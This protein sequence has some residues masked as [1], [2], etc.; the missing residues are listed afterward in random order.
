MDYRET[1]TGACERIEEAAGQFCV[2][3]IA[4]ECRRY[5]N[6]HINDT[7]LLRTEDGE[8][9][10]A[11][12]L[13]R[14]NTH[15]FQ[16]PEDLMRNVSGV[17][18]YLRDQIIKGGGDPQRETLT[19]VKTK[20]GKDC[21]VDSLGSWW[22]MYLFIPDALGYDTAEKEG[23]FYQSAKAFGH[24]QRLLAG[25]PVQKLT[26]TIPDFHNT[27]KRFEAFCRAVEKDVCGRAQGVGSEIAFVMDRKTEMSIVTDKLESGEIPRRVTHN[28]TKLNNVL[29]DIRS[30]QAV[31]VID[32][33]TVMPGTAVYDF[34]DSIRFGANTAEEDER[35]LSR[36]SL[37][38]P[39]YETYTKGFLEGCAGSLTDEEIR[40]L[41]WG[42]K[43]MTL[44]CGMRFLTDYLEGDRYFRIHRPEHNLDRARTQF[45]LAA[46]MER[47]WDE[48][49]RLA[50]E[51]IFG[52]AGAESESVR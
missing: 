27:P 10:H 45:A 15:V 21:Y 40:L 24:F 14:M 6:G 2:A 47:K 33:D 50:E 28:D 7:F 16:N 8:R 26:E 12:I 9:S 49:G 32:L 1:A 3:G 25:Y 38:L 11:Y 51:S 48:M 30:G 42:A 18:E 22:R 34:G 43:L 20:A 44:E 46:D 23:I 13:Q 5:G 52:T 31:C 37:S 17:T 19:L 41:P 4:S 36:V 35:D 39:L 29:I